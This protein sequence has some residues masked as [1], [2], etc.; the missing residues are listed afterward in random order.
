MKSMSHRRFCKIPRCCGTRPVADANSY[1][2]IWT[3]TPWTLPG[4]RAMAYAENLTYG[5]YQAG[6]DKL[7]LC[8]TLVDQVIRPQILKLRAPE[9]IDPAR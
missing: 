1:A 9:D 4:N 7:I 8:D 6:G 5:V 3:T 2:V